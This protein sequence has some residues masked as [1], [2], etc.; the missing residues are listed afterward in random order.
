[1]LNHPFLKVV[2]SKFTWIRRAHIIWQVLE[3]AIFFSDQRLGPNDFTNK[4]TR[5][6]PTDDLGVLIKDAQRNKLLDSVTT[7][8]QWKNQDN[9]KNWSTHYVK[10]NGGT[11]QANGGFPVP[12]QC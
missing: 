8:R 12:S 4:G 2:K 7:P 3:E 10:G 9:E 1:M 6:S 5:I 11:M